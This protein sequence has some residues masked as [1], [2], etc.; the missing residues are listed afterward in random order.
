M[1]YDLSLIPAVGYSLEGLER[2]CAITVALKI[3]DESCKMD[4]SEKELFMRLYRSIREEESALFTAQ[5]YHLI[6]TA[7]D[8]PSASLFWEI[9]R[10]REAAMEVITRPKMK[11]FKAMVRKR[12]TP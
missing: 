10:L 8:S 6:D 4:I 12:I 5:V 7:I 2:D 1:P 3:A 9:R 11:A